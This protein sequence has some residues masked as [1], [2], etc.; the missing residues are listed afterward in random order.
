MN[1]INLA[2]LSSQ[3]A[4]PRRRTSLAVETMEHRLVLSTTVLLPSAQAASMVRNYWP[5]APIRTEAVSFYPPTPVRTPVVSFWPP[6]PI[7][8]PVYFP[9]VPI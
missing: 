9:P 2:L 8:T 1:A 7:R 4:R 6:N 3:K 5:P